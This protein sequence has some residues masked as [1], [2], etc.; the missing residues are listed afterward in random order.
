MLAIERLVIGDEYPIAL[1]P[2]QQDSADFRAAARQREECIHHRQPDIVQYAGG[3]FDVERTFGGSPLGHCD[4][5]AVFHA[6]SS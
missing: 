2:A 6:F 5:G 4:V 1:L 3:V